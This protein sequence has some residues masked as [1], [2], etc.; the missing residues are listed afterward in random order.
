MSLA[1]RHRMNMAAK[2]AAAA[3][4]ELP[5]A[6]TAAIEEGSSIA[7][8][9]KLRLMLDLRRLK[10]IQS[11]E[12]K[13]DAKREML[14]EYASWVEGILQ[15]TAETGVGVEDEVLATVMIWRIDVGDYAAALPLIDYV[16][17]WNLALPKR[18]LRTAA[19]LIVE[20]IAD[21]ALKRLS[22]GEDFPLDILTDIETLT[23]DHDMHD[24]VRAKL[25]K[26]IGLVAAAR[27]DLAEDASDGPAGG[28]R[29]AQEQALAALRRAQ[30]L[31]AKAGVVKSIEKIERELKKDAGTSPSAPN[32]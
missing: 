21:A 22:Q 6:S 23:E 12:R 16:L 29:A 3:A 7:D 13:I 4:A 1:R 30:G 17:R 8:Q 10:E 31:N 18:Y 5:E 9:V 32:A 25:M 28:K 2:V 14:P 24:E 27:A 15:A 20:E 19:T 11:I 26:A